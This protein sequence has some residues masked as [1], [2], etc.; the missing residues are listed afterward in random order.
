MQ[1]KRLLIIVLAIPLAI[2]GLIGL[3]AVG[4]SVPFIRQVVGFVCLSFIPGILILRALRV[5]R[6]SMAETLCYGVGLS[7]AAVIITGFLV[8]M[9]GRALGVSQPLTATNL[10]I[11]LTILVFALFWAGYGRG[12]RVSETTFN[13]RELLS[14]SLLFLLL[15]PLLSILGTLV[16]NYYAD[17]TLLLVL[18]PVI[19]LIALLVALKKFIPERWYGLAIFVISLA[20][21]YHKSLVSM[22]VVGPDV[23]VELYYTRLTLLNSFWDP[24]ISHVYNAMLGI[25]ILPANYSLAMNI[26]A[27]WVFK[28]VFPLFFALSPLALYQAFVKQTDSRSAFLAVFFFISLTAF[29]NIAMSV[30]KMA[31]ACLFLALIVLLLTDNTI[32]QR[33]KI[34]MAALF[35]GCVIV[36]H[37]GTALI[38]FFILLAGFLLLSMTRAGRKS[39]SFIT[40]GFVALLYIILALA[41]FL[42]VG[43]GEVFKSFIDIGQRVFNSIVD[44]F[45]F[46]A[47]N[48]QTQQVLNV[49]EAISWGENIRYYFYWITLLF[50]ILGV[51]KLL[52]TYIRY[53]EIP[54]RLEYAVMSLPSLA[55]IGAMILPYFSQAMG[56]DRFLYIVLF[57]LSPFCILGG[58]AFF[59]FII[60]PLRLLKIP[61]QNVG[62]TLLVVA[63]LIPYFLFNYG[64]V[65]EVSGDMPLA[66]LSVPLG[67]PRMQDSDDEMVK[68]RFYNTYSYEQEVIAAQWLSAERDPDIPVYT[69]Y[70]SAHPLAS[71]GLMYPYNRVVY[72]PRDKPHRYMYLGYM[73]VVDELLSSRS[74]EDWARGTYGLKTYNA[75]EFLG[76]FGDKIYDNGGSAVYYRQ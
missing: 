4:L 38:F 72:P 46:A 69:D 25:T 48:P 23:N 5:S 55:I 44:L 12:E 42:A 34:I 60:K 53:R 37:Y 41:W 65:Q 70:V 76:L 47:M 62:L 24:G 19:A 29:A 22:Y 67:L 64:F 57:F 15:I 16:I 58:R 54:L 1:G 45:N 51:I 74:S 18:V 59:D 6:L 71:A 3:Q 14:P 61:L 49:A 68:V 31:L 20:L 21:I 52:I 66:P 75:A 33:D 7:L 43:K 27:A 73:A 30:T 36:S 2:L 11:G 9:I 32:K 40:I 17:N 35:S 13:W 39:P 8:N 63:V 26:D 56:S 28:A 50:I 10:I